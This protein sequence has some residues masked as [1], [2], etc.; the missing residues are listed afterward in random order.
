MSKPPIARSL[1][2]IVTVSLAVLVLS[3]CGGAGLATPT[4]IPAD[5]VRPDQPTPV[6]S[7]A[8]PRFRLEESPREPVIVTT[9]EAQTPDAFDG[10]SLEEKRAALL[11][12]WLMD[13]P[14]SALGIAPGGASIVDNPGGRVIASLPA[15]GTVTVTGRSADGA[16]LAVF[17]EGAVGGWV[18]AG[19]LILYGADDLTVVDK[20]FAPAPVATLLAEAMLP[21]STPLAAII[22]RRA[23]T[24]EAIA[25][26]AAGD[27]QAGEGG[28]L[29]VSVGRISG[30]NNVNLR[31][32][33]STGT[34]VLASLAPGSNLIV[35][36]RSEDGA[37]YQVRTPEGDGWV[38]AS[39]VEIG[40]R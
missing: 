38:A 1:R 29:Q 28:P 13:Q 18:P 39:L 3:A 37:W 4:A 10:A 25:P 17:T 32:G 36:R 5:V 7:T 26:D 30:G 23:Q 22:E 2:A 33:P 11:A 20:P 27:G 34:T 8:M 24:P 35:F 19:S 14:P 40:D 21:V 9:P 6:L 31:A 12:S 16:W 15:A